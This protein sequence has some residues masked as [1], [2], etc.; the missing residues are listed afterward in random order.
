M[1]EWRL[2]VNQFIDDYSEGPNICLLAVDIVDKSLWR[3][4]QRGAYVQIFELLS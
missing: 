1:R 2:N 3:H 4:V